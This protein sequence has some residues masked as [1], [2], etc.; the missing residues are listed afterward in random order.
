MNYRLMFG[1]D[2]HKKM[3]DITTIH[4]Y[5]KGFELVQLDIM[6][7]IKDLEVTH[8]MSL[9]D[10][11]D[12]GYGSDTAAALAHTDIDREM[13]NLLNGNFY[14]LI[15]NH[16]KI[17]MDSN[18]ELFLIQPHPYY[19]SR[20]RVNRDYQIIRT[21]KELVLNGVQI[22]FMHWNK[23]AESA[24]EYKAM[25]RPE[26]KY[27]IGLYHTENIIPA[28]IL[29]SINMYASMND[30][31]KIGAALEGIDLA[32]VGH[33]H[34]PIGAFNISKVSGGTTK[35]IVP[36]SLTNTDAGE[37]ARHDYIDMPIVDISENGEV[38]VSYHRQSLHTDVLTFSP[39]K[40]S[41]SSRDKLKSLRGNTKETLYEEL[42]STTFVGESKGF[43]TLGMFMRQNG[44]TPA[45]R[46]L[47]RNTLHSPDDIDILMQIYKEGNHGIE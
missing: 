43:Q 22:C 3:I 32:I 8:F 24:Y 28:H 34:K 9:G 29:T 33:V 7:A 36:G 13:Y 6:K 45:D 40:I 23:D 21:P 20:H 31:S 42:E 12:S 1:G 47:V 38:S 46:A 26:C 30:N 11:F 37:S 19:I 16:I 5:T 35:M 4:G 44:Y 15:G 2:L 25:I 17:R 14:G 41:V 39:K 18:P 10:W 27:H